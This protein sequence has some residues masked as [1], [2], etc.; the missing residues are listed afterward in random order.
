M[1]GRKLYRGFH[2]Q[3]RDLSR[4]LPGLFLRR[5]NTA[6]RYSWKE[7]GEIEIEMNDSK[8]VDLEAV[9][10]NDLCVISDPW[11]KTVELRVTDGKE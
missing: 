2:L 6:N 11:I 7:S 4:S 5:E 3:N 1:G 10:A 8:T 9:V